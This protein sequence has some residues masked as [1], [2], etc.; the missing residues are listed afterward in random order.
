MHPPARRLRPLPPLLAVLALLL[1]TC[2]PAPPPVLAPLAVQP[3]HTPVILVPGVTGVKMRE[4]A[5]GRVVWGRGKDLLV[6]H[7]GGYALALP[8]PAQLEND[9]AALDA[10]QPFEVLDTI[11]LAGIRKPI[12]QPIYDLL[13]AN[14]YTRGDLADPRPGEDFFPFVYDWRRDKT[15]TAARLA[16]RLEAL[17]RARGEPRLH[18]V[19]ICQSCGAHICRWLAKYGGATL[20]QAEA[21]RAAPPPTLEVEKIILVGSSNGGSIRILREIDR[22]RGYLPLGRRWRPE[23]LFTLPSLYQDLPAYRTD[24]FVD[25]SGEPLDLDLYD[26]AVWVAQGW[27]VFD[28]GVQRRLA[29]HPRPELFG[30]AAAR[31]RHLARMLDRARR[32][33]RLLHTDAPGFGATRYYSVQSLSVPTPER[34]V[35]VDGH[36]GPELL[37][38]GDRRLRRLAGLHAEVTARGDEHA[39]EVSQRWLSPQETAALAAEPVIVDGGHFELLLA[40]ESERSFLRFLL[41]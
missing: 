5:G 41:E 34:A 6:P 29:R 24:L 35:V 27:S 2:A 7:D 18:V 13:A 3:A 38:T 33:Q 23:V 1:T 21:G 39:S 9:S 32:F 8:I 16:E 31:R 22:G 11:R 14:G 40:A 37:F 19:L 36:R 28:P 20:E 26:P 30:D 4:R 15:E 10:L 12:Y 17:R 25:G